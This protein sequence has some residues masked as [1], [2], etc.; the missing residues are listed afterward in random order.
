MFSFYSDM[1]I[2]KQNN[3]VNF[4]SNPLYHVN[5]K[6]VENKVEVGV[7]R[8]LFSMLSPKEKIDEQAI[9]EI[10]EHLR[11]DDTIGRRF[12]NDFFNKQSDQYD[13][14][15]IEKEGDEPL[16]K[17]IMGFA[18]SFVNEED[19]HLSYLFIKPEFQKENP[20]RNL[21]D[22]GKTMMAIIF[23]KAKTLK[24]QRVTFN[25]YCDKF[26]LKILEDAH[27][28]LNHGK[29]YFIKS[30]FD[31]WGTDFFIHRDDCKKYL[32]YM[33]NEYGVDFSQKIQNGIES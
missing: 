25:S 33:K 20:N 22:V 30:D 32:K 15:A 23:N 31:E 24:L 4:K 9:E 1:L 17:K 16:S 21:K 18:R 12:C 13:D 29:S 11:K 2:S 10:S 19:Y 6:K 14:F 7:Q 26:Y 28:Q 27:I 3:S 5:L 8:A